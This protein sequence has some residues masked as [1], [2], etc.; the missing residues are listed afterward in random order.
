MI[1]K[2]TTLT[3]LFAAAALVAAAPQA[4]APQKPPD[5]AVTLTG[6]NGQPP[7][8]AVPQ[9]IA[10][11]KDAE[12][13]A[14]AKTITDVLFD[15]LTFEREY[16]LIPR[17]T[18][19]TIPAATSFTDVPIDR[20]RELN[21]D[22]VVVGTVQKMPTGIQIQVRLLAAR[23]RSQ[24]FGKEYSGSSAN[25]RIYAH[26]ISDELHALRGVR[27]IARTKIAFASDR[28]G[29]RLGGTIEQRTVQEVYM[30]DYDGEGAR[31]LTVNRTLNITPRWSP[32][33]R[34]L[35]YTS[36]RRG[37]PNIFI[38]N[39]YEGTNSDLTKDGASYLPAWSPDGTRIAFMSTHDGN[40]ELYVANRDGS[41][42]R[43]ITN[44]PA[45]D[46]APTWSPAGNQIAFVSDR[47]GSP[48]VYIVNADGTGLQR[49]TTAESYADKPTW[50]PAPNSEIA[51]SSRNGPGSDIKVINLATR[52]IRQLTFGEG[53]N[54]SPTWAPNGRHLAFVSTRAGKNQI[55]TIS[56][57]GKNL[58]QITKVGNNKFPDW[59]N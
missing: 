27:G 51:F 54:E 46:E 31:R 30:E 37:G 56:A 53:T 23:D 12:T 8:L 34:S 16:A 5:I 44:N 58:R 9:F 48:Q 22:Y 55:F 18:Y 40:P 36:Y 35:A 1:D 32:D 45:I 33:G 2:L 15:D 3:T 57:D 41:N 49:L 29:E 52:M 59:S 11:T 50:S 25:P 26:T 24:A 42:V 10:I 7:R 14:I 6:E 47:T 17:D 19:A 38:Q 13:Q 43:R 39:I 20:W 4:P 28:D 21:A